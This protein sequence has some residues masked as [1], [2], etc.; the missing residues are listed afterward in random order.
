MVAAGPLSPGA[1]AVRQ[2]FQPAAASL[3][4]EQRLQQAGLELLGN[5][6]KMSG[7][8]PALLTQSPLLEDFTAHTSWT[9]WARPCCWS[10]R[11]PARC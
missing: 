10:V 6:Q 8:G 7:R 2:A 3:T 9:P 5:C 11:N 1:S 4:L